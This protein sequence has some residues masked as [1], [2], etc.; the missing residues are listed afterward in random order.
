M[1]ST[2]AFS[3]LLLFPLGACEAP[4][5]AT[6][7][8][9]PMP[10]QPSAPPAAL[11]PDSE[12][13]PAAPEADP[14][15]P[16]YGEP[17]EF[18]A[19]YVVSPVAGSKRLQGGSLELDDGES[20]IVSYRPIRSQL[21]YVDRRVTV[22]GRPYWNSPMVQSVGG[23]H[24]EVESMELA[25]GES[26]YD[27][28]PTELPAPPQ[29]RTLEELRARL[30]RWRWCHAIGTLVSLRDDPDTTYWHSGELRLA[31]GTPLPLIHIP[32]RDETFEAL[33]GQEVTILARLIGDGT[34]TPFQLSAATVCPGVVERCRMS[35]DNTRDR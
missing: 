30:G 6:Q 22:R 2:R 25:P 34:D 1:R 20:W 31:D 29:V 9:E 28:L 14:Y 16:T 7:T 13:T 18:E 5:R 33:L 17:V 35:L 10:K 15:A 26:P 24:F 11:A 8:A 27:P 3:L 12:T 23:T 19:L 21:Q 4:T 32:T